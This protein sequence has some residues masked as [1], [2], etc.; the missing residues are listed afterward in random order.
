MVEKIVIALAILASVGLFARRSAELMGYL[1]LGQPEDRVPRRWAR[2]LK[3]EVVV[4]LGQRKLLQWS[5]PG[6][7]HFLIFWG[8]IVLL[9]T[10]VEGFG[11]IY[12]DRFHIPFIGKWGP[13]GAL[14]DAFVVAVLVGIATAFGIRK[15]QR[16]GRFKG[17][18]LREADYIL[19]AIG[20]IMLTILLARAAAIALDRFPY[21][22]RWTPLSN[23]VAPL[24]R[25]PSAAVTEA[26]AT[27]L[28]WWHSLLILG[29]L[30]YL[31]YSKHLHI[32]TSGPNV[33]LT[34]E[35]PKGA[36]KPMHLDMENVS[37][38]ATFGAAKITD[39]TWKQ[40]L[41]TY[42]CT[43]C[44]RCQSQCPAW[45]T[46][47]PLSPK[48][49]IMDLRDALFE[50][51]PRL[52][53]AKRQSQEAFEAALE[54]LGPLNPD[55]V[56]DEV[57]WDCTTCGACVQACPVNIEHIDA[58]VD[59]RRNLVM[60]ES[61]FPREMQ[62]ALQNMETTGNP[63][64]Q[65]P[66]ARMDWAKGSSRQDPLEIPLAGDA[67]G[68]EVL[69]WVGCAGAFDDR[70]RRVLYD[71]ASLLQLAGVSFSVLGG[72]ESCTGDPAR[73][74]GAEYIYQTLAEQNIE[75]LR[76]HDFKTIVTACPHCFNTIFNEYPQFGGYFDVVHHT[77]YLARLVAAGRLRPRIPMGESITYHDPCYNARHNDVW[78]GA[79]SV[80]ES[81]PHATYREM[82]RHKHTTFCCGAGGGRMWMEERM[83]RKV[84]IERT[85]E[86][87]ASASDTLAVGCPF[88]N[89]MLADGIAERHADSNMVVKDVAQLLR[90]S[91]D[92]PA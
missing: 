27:V 44:G 80:I 87:L 66:Q 37:E 53:T 29:F 34:S 54:E 85:D 63:W 1:R 41:D 30:V 21:D 91:V 68:A 61:R 8:F 72:D 50:A 82:P 56:E 78:K 55:V 73:R 14:Q 46:A 2:K 47:K 76:R 4:V 74:M 6:V 40:L 65:P 32:I 58:I 45:N 26:L 33:L 89:I 35:R 24:F 13:L 69:L 81:I 62:T 59:M 31:T 23:G 18:H 38:D 7:M 5:I 19:L 88:C 79:R 60:G 17:S 70:N 77:E 64:G 20:G 57:I 90:E 49:L 67:P 28:L 92:P 10:I 12:Q 25:G 11:S 3:D 16:P 75:Q 9:T 22:S 52:M 86:A 15:L 48:L 42:T 71:L 51:G 43:E 84:N 83:G 39:L 36:L